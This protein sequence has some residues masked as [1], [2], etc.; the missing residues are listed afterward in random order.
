MPTN[1]SSFAQD[2]PVLRL[3]ALCD[4][5][6]GSDVVQRIEAIL[7]IYLTEG[8][9]YQVQTAFNALAA[10]EKKYGRVALRLRAKSNDKEKAGKII[11]ANL[12]RLTHKLAEIQVARQSG[13]IPALLKMLPEQAA[14]NLVKSLQPRLLGVINNPLFDLWLVLLDEESAQRL[15]RCKNQACRKFFLAW[16]RKKEYCSGTCRNQSWNRPRRAASGHRK[17]RSTRH[18]P[19]SSR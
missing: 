9:S 11:E 7:D 8:P 3:I 10:R 16:P 17:P 6:R 18:K 19:R 15:K 12:K 4:S 1:H 14:I 5:Q 2:S 13:N